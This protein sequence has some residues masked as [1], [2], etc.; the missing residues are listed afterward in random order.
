M[1]EPTIS[2]GMIAEIS[3]TAVIAAFLIRVQEF[4][5]SHPQLVCLQQRI[6]HDPSS[7]S[8]LAL[9]SFAGRAP[10]KGFNAHAPI[11]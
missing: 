10:E 11:T 7:L 9:E 4:Y 2:P 6:S 5:L 3:V 1:K 8:W